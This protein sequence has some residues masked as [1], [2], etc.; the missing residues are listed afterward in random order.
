MAGAQSVN[1]VNL[2]LI[3]EIS[4]KLFTPASCQAISRRCYGDYKKA[5][6]SELTCDL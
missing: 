3:C 4:Q 2:V 5:N 1:T 6:S